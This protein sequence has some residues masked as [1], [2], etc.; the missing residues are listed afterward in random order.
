[1]EDKHTVTILGLGNILLGDEGFGVH[2]INRFGER[3]RL[4]EGVQAVDGGVLGLGLLSIITGTRH[5]I[6]IDT[7]KVKDQPGSIFRFT[8]Q[9]MSLHLP[10]PTS[11][12]EVE[13]LDVLAMAELMEECPPV[14]FIVV[15]PK[16]Y[17][18]MEIGMT[19]VMADRFSDVEELLLKEL[20]SLGVRPE[21]IQR[22]TS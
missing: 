12:H 17:G 22:C 10:P 18:T 7:I 21:R 13:F 15:V 9:E 1:M 6:V 14:V 8:K 5:L 16:K 20:S 4:P 3:Y 19:D 11:A 2:F